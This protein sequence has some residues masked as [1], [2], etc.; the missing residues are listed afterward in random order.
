MHEK[1]GASFTL[2]NGLLFGGGAIDDQVVRVRHFQTA[3]L[4]AEIGLGFE[5]SQG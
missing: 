5:D 3:A 4:A 1:I 2:F